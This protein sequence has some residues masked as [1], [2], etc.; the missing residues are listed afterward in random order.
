MGRGVIVRPDVVHSYNPNGALG[1]MLFVDPE[2]AEGM[3]LRTSLRDDITL[4]PEARLTACADELRRFVKQP[5]ER[6]DIRDLVRHCVHALCTGAPPSRRIDA[7]VTR[8]LAAIRASDEL[9]MSIE[10]AAAIVFLS[11]SRF[12]HLFKQQV[13]LPFRRYMLWR[14]LTRAMLVIGRERTI[15]TAAHA[16]DF[17]DAAHLT[18]TFYQMVGIAPSVLMRGE[19][20]EIPSPFEVSG[21]SQ[22]NA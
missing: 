2:S 14:K 17:A 11:P 20:F 19:F 16:A 3:W 1:A 22:P 21:A 8:V 15:A 5:F 10:D 6:M 18:R 12:A 9:R 7:R 13:G 4:V